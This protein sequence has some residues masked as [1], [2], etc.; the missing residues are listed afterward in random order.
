MPAFLSPPISQACGMLDRTALHILRVD[1]GFPFHGD[2]MIE[3]MKE[4]K[5]KTKKNMLSSVQHTLP[6]SKSSP[7]PHP[8]HPRVMIDDGLGV[9]PSAI[10]GR[11]RK[12]HFIK[13]KPLPLSSFSVSLCT[14][15]RFISA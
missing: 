13:V 14:L 6:P 4:K 7:S 1:D 8:P 15:P 9:S 2:W 5:R 10:Y 3:Y 11:L 12:S